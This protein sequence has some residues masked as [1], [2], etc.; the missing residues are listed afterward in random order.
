M[1]LALDKDTHDLILPDGGGVSR[2]SEGRFVVQQVKS[3]L[4]AWLGE[5]ELN[6]NVGWLSFS[7]FERN[8]DLFLIESKARQVILGTQ[9]V[10]SIESLVMNLESRMLTIQFKAKTKYGEIDLT[11]A[12]GKE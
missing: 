6:P 8:P 1:H 5:W 4:M 10:S 12:W 11:V 9:G 7:D 2:V 3:K